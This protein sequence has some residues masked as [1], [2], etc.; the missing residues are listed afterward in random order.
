MY[1]LKNE[2]FE[3]LKNTADALELIQPEQITLYETRYNMNSLDYTKLNRDI[4]YDQ[5]SYLFERI[6]RMGYKGEFGQNTFSRYEDQGVSAYLYHRMM[7]GKAYKGFGISAQSMS[8][9]GISYNSLKMCN[10]RYLPQIQ[11]IVEEDI[12][13]LPP[14]EIVAKYVC[15]ALYSG[16]FSLKVIS[17]I[18]G[19][20]PH[21][22]YKEEL[23]YLLE[24]GYINI[25]DDVVWLT[26]KGFRVYGAIAAF[27]WSAASKERYLSF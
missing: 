16:R 2:T 15:V 24:G 20:D 4:L 21:E 19:G 25:R 11:E 26:Q 7:E 10:D 27:F 18:L 8:N 1:G 5:Y 3:M 22:I 12:Y 23:Q 6:K 17:G 13:W 14:E 9:Y